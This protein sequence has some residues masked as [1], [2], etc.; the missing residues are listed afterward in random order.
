MSDGRGKIHTGTG[1]LIRLRY[2]LIAAAIV[3]SLPLYGQDSMRISMAYPV[4]SQYLQN[5][6]VIN[7]AYAGSREALSTLISYR[8]QWI[9][10]P[11]SP[12]LQSLTFHSPM[13]SDKV[14]LGLKAQFMG[15]GATKSSSVYGMYAYHIR[16]G[17]SKLSFGLQGGVDISNTDYSGIRETLISQDDAVFNT[18]DQPYIL[19]NVGAG[20]YYFNERFFVG[21]SVPS[22]LSY[23][24]ASSGKV[25]AYH[26]V[27]DY[28]FLISAGALITFSP[29]FK[30]KPSVLVDYS[31]QKTEKLSQL[32]INGNFIIADLIWIGGSYR[33]SE[34]VAVGILQIFPAQQLMIGLSYDYPVGN[35]N[36]STKGSAEV[37]LRYEFG[38]RV[39]AANPRYF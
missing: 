7:P 5:G 2:C 13:K 22:F 6:L 10:V 19:P 34:K 29:V 30:F 39:S 35:T 16:M 38:S 25:Q 23:R 32:D 4:F 3:L 24:K 28:N 20:A 33:T 12:K 14:A 36:L 21:L 11:G 1:F 31:L 26:S 8:Y 15:Y 17:D 37:V 9:N 27:S 18:S